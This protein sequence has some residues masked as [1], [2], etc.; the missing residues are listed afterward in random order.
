MNNFYDL[1]IGDWVTS[2][3]YPGV[4]SKIANLNVFSIEVTLRDADDYYPKSVFR[5]TV[6]PILLSP[7]I[8]E[9][10]GFICE[11]AKGVMKKVSDKCYKRKLGDKSFIAVYGDVVHIDIQNG[12]CSGIPMFSLTR[13][14]Y[15]HE[16][17]HILSD[18]GLNDLASGFIVE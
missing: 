6:N 3:E 11:D 12:I 18:C 4:Y 9:L 2:T 13:C 15:V 7:E 8:L 1:K 14:K 16:L 10:N 5:T 17:Q